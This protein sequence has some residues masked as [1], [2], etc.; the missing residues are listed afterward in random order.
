[1]A[2]INTNAKLSLYFF[3]SAVATLKVNSFPKAKLIKA[4]RGELD[5]FSFLSTLI[6]LSEKTTFCGF[7]G[8]I[9]K[10]V[11]MSSHVTSSL[12]CINYSEAR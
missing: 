2:I 12:L 1:M 3:A 7:K 8:V 6:W 5:L 10:V 9:R 11:K 4:K